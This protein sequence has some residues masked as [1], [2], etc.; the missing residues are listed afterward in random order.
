[1]ST[2]VCFAVVIVWVCVHWVSFRFSYFFFLL[3]SKSVS[4]TLDIHSL[5]LRPSTRTAHILGMTVPV[6]Y[7]DDV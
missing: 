1:M 6:S 5:E 3:L 7:S 2:H 4:Q